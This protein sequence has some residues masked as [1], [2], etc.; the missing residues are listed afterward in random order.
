MK[1]NQRGVSMVSLVITII[2]I[3]ILAAVAFSG[4]RETIGRAEFS[5][6][7]T[8]IDSVRTAF[9]TEGV[10]S[11]MG[12][13]ET[14]NNTVTK[15][16]AYNYLAKGATT[17]RLDKED[18]KHAWLSKSQANAIP[19]TRIEKEYAKD[20]IGIKL[21]KR[22]VNTYEATGVEIE[23][24]VTNKGDIFTWPP[25]FRSDDGLFYV[26]DTIAVAGS[27]V[28]SGD[29]LISGDDEAKMYE[30]GFKF[31]VNGVEIK[32]Q[33]T[34]VALTPITVEL[35]PN[36]IK[37]MASIGY[38]D[39]RNP[40]Q[41]IGLETVEVYQDDGTSAG[42]NNGEGGN[43]GSGGEETCTHSWDEGVQTVAPTTTTTGVKTYTCTL[44]G[45]TKTEEIPMIAGN[46]IVSV[47]KVGDYVNYSANGVTSW[48]VFDI[49]NGEVL[50]TPASG[51]VG[52][53]Q[54]SG[55]KG[56]DTAVTEIE[57]KCDDYI[58]SSLGITASNVRSMTVEDINRVAGY[59]PAA[60][61]T[62]YA[63]FLN[64]DSTYSSATVESGYTKAKH[65]SSL[66]NGWTTPRFYTWDNVG[67]PAT[68]YDEN[69]IQ[70]AY[71]TEGNPVYVTKTY[72]NYNPSSY[73]HVSNSSITV[74]SLLGSRYGWLASP[75]VTAYS[76]GADFYVRRACASV[77]NTDY[78]VFSDGY[79]YS[80]SYG[81]RPLVSLGSGL[82][83]TRADDNSPWVLSR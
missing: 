62:K 76:A 79:T 61:T 82:Q 64:S 54:L 57:K 36:T 9:I 53:L 59:T 58:N 6:Y 49:R 7:T 44:C 60:S 56:Y 66:Y 68:D 4:S 5:G 67:N 25:F 21:P 39:E 15:A 52:T 83:A 70:Y 12:E 40:E 77:V 14:K 81:V 48:R 34:G 72:Y 73:N 17:K 47:A 43:E 22:K 35:E 13:E 18:K 29:W 80:P 10:T 41:P 8:D 19:C 74:G 38:K 31:M 46:S 42:G 63:Y 24:F 11:L 26:N 28:T 32:I 30:D 37:G 55:A 75:C 3:I 1:Q 45:E 50:I 33:G 16:Q 51:P 20:A 2:V 69:G 27:K 65:Q 23:Y 71:P 78:L